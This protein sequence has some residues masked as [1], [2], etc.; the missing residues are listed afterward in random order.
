[1][2]KSFVLPIF[3]A[4]NL[5]L[6]ASNVAPDVPRSNSAALTEVIVRFK[7]QPTSDDLKQL[8]T[9]GQVKRSLNIIRAVHIALPQKAI[10]TL[11]TN[12]KIA[13]ISPNRSSKGALDI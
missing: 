2:K 6:G 12:P 4:A 13:Y 10:Q 7:S 3:A 5:L 9:I 1:M 8:A 11:A